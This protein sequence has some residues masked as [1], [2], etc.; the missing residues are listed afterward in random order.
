VDG[1]LD[2]AV[3]GVLPHDG[4]VFFQF[5]TVGSVLAV[6][7]RD[8]TRCAR[9]AAVFVLR[10]FQND[11][12]AVAFAFLCHCIFILRLERLRGLNS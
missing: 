5:H 8:V 6:F 9:K 12:D 2:F 10:T 1:L 7:L 11:L 4:I 3:N